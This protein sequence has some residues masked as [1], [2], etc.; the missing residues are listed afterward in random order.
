MERDTPAGYRRWSNTIY[1]RRWDTEKIG[2]N[3][4]NSALFIKSVRSFRYQRK[5]KPRSEK[6]DGVFPFI[7]CLLTRTETFA[8]VIKY[9]V[10]SYRTLCWT[11]FSIVSASNK[12][13]MFWDPE[14]SSGWPKNTFSKVSNLTNPRRMIFLIKNLKRGDS[15]YPTPAGCILWTEYMFSM[16]NQA[17]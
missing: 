11:C 17:S 13:N 6:S 3:R 7:V 12:I 5:Q 4:D 8:K 15:P 16:I 14:T 10:M 9:C 2:I 1:R